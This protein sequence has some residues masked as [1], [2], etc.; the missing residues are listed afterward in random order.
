[1]IYV[2]HYIGRCAARLRLRIVST[3]GG[4]SNGEVE[5]S[6]C[7]ERVFDIRES[8]ISLDSRASFKLLAISTIWARLAWRST[9]FSFGSWRSHSTG[10]RSFLARAGW[11]RPSLAVG[12]PRAPFLER[13]DGLDPG[14][15]VL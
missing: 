13:E 8:R 15:V 11:L 5:A 10:A 4:C 9:M 6:R 2:S 7:F 3:C 12:S 1:M 14:D